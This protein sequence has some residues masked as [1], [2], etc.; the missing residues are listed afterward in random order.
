M[1]LTAASAVPQTHGVM[2]ERFPSEIIKLAR[3][4]LR[5]SKSAVPL[6]RILDI[7]SEPDADIGT[8]ANRLPRVDNSELRQGFA[9]LSRLLRELERQIG[10]TQLG[11]PQMSLPAAKE[12]F[13]TDGPTISPGVQV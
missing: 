2:A 4:A 7:L 9:A 5:L 1:A 12:T 11:E 10:P 3:T 8:V 13:P 6:W